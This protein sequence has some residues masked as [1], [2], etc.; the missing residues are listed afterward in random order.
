MA[1]NLDLLLLEIFL[2]FS[3][4][5]MV[6]SS[7]KAQL[8]VSW[9]RPKKDPGPNRERSSAMAPGV[10]TILSNKANTSLGFLG[11]S[12]AQIVEGL[13]AFTFL[14]INKI[15]KNIEQV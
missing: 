8:I 10:E 14:T 2:H 4:G 7:P 6:T 15:K 13:V 9:K 5:A 11:V 3:Y 1:F 12:D